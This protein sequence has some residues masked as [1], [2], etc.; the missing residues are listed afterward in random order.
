MQL[1][2]SYHCYLLVGH[3]LTSM[4]LCHALSIFYSFHILNLCQISITI[5]FSKAIIIPIINFL[6]NHCTQLK[7]KVYDE[8]AGFKSSQF[9]MC[10]LTLCVSML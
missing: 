9:T 4:Q 2:Q 6:I 5:N 1:L 7:L 3:V 10:V 8:I